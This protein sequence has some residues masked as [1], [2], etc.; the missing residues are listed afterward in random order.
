ME[1]ARTTRRLRVSVSAMC[2]KATGFGTRDGLHW[3]DPVES[4]QSGYTNY[5]P[6]S[7]LK[8]RQRR[9]GVRFFSVRDRESTQTCNNTFLTSESVY[10]I[11]RRSGLVTISFIHGASLDSVEGSSIRPMP[12]RLILVACSSSGRSGPIL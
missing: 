4:W 3:T 11:G 8:Q 7:V 10:F 5:F 9:E 6:S 12:L 1:L 2:N